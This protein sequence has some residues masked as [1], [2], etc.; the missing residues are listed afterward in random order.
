MRTRKLQTIFDN[1][2]MLQECPLFLNAPMPGHKSTEEE[3]RVRKP[4]N[5]YLNHGA[6]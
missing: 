3:V 4:Y 5:T 6:V 2:R 1:E